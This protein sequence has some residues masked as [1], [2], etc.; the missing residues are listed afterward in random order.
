MRQFYKKGAVVTACLAEATLFAA[1]ENSKTVIEHHPNVLFIAVD[2]LRPELGCYG[3]KIIQTPNIDQLAASGTLFT[4]QYV[5][6]PTCGASRYALLTGLYPRSRS[7]LCNLAAE[8]GK[9]A[10]SSG[11]S[12]KA[13]TM[14]ELF[15]KNGYRTICIGK[16]S[17]M[18]D[19]K[20]FN[21]NGTGSGQVELPDAWDEFA[22]PY[23]PWKYGYGAFFAY[24]NGRHSRDGSGYRPLWEFPDVKDSELPDGMKAD[25]AIKK[26]DELSE[27]GQPFFIGLGFYKPHLP[28]VAP[29]KYRD[30][31]NDIA[32]PST[33]GMK[34]G[35]TQCWNQSGEFYSYHPPFERPKGKEAISE[36]DAEDVRRAYYACATYVDA[37][38]GRV[39]DE[40]KKRGLD[41]NTI[42][43]LWG[44]HG[45]HLGE[46][47]IW[48]KHT[49]LEKALRSPLI[50]VDPKMKSKGVKSDAIVET[51]DIYP[52]LLDLC[53]LKNRNTAKPLNGKSLRPILEN[54]EKSV[55]DIAI[56][57][58]GPRTSITD[59]VYR[60]I[61]SKNKA[62]TEY[63]YELYD[64]KTDPGELKNIA[65]QHPERIAEMMKQLKK[66]YPEILITQ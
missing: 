23:G 28:F 29:K 53:N 50:I 22:T 64:H 9:S 44:D 54:Q 36:K 48:G 47:N 61:I 57:F 42:I 24:G 2:D 19:G 8:K 25:V 58:W 49:A 32:I 63:F 14:P 18:P 26:L 66:E 41:K 35:D 4:K 52:T 37:Q 43:V 56:S 16:V 31:Y 7:A 20:V 15:R 45:W 27:S 40:L 51:V 60:L 11:P 62:T 1:A 34:I 3:N 5:Q 10:L 33:Y 12:E 6:V 46:H 39:L 55:R 21:Y 38:I 59:G 13:R 17:H 65:K 30:L